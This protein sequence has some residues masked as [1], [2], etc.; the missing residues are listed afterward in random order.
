MENN[1]T[2]A[3]LT[4]YIQQPGSM[5]KSVVNDL[6]KV[7]RKYPS[8]QLA[9]VLLAKNLLNTKHKAYPLSLKLASAYAS[10][11]A[12]LKIFLDEKP[13]V[14]QSV[15]KIQDTYNAHQEVAAQNL[16]VAKTQQEVTDIKDEKPVI[17]SHTE[18]TNEQLNKLINRI[19]TKLSENSPENINTSAG[20]DEQYTDTQDQEDETYSQQ[21]LIDAFISNQPSIK[22]KKGDFFRPYN[23]AKQSDTKPDDLVSEALAEIY[24]NQGHFDKAIEIYEK[25]ILLNPEKSVYFANQIKEIQK[26]QNFIS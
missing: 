13:F 6:W 16:E 14:N 23:I 2:I 24:K 8:F 5:D 1:I 21:D 25:L 15:D 11:R 18:T 3:H 19:R 10:D 9:R 7:I 12:M 17:I 26:S 4:R 22:P 20:Y